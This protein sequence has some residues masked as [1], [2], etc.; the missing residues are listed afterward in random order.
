MSFPR[1]PEYKDSGVEWLG[2]VPAH[3]GAGRL[4][5]MCKR[6]AGGTPDRANPSFWENGSIPWLNSG[7]VN[8]RVITKPSEF[9]TLE[10][11]ERSSARWIRVQLRPDPSA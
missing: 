4:K 1:Y 10:G 2:Q 3:W 5:W 6:Y 9:I 11:F 7:A 8:D